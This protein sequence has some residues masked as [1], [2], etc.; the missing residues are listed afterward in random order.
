MA[1]TTLINSINFDKLLHSSGH[2][3]KLQDDF[4]NY[5]SEPEVLSSSHTQNELLS[6]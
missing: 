6:L 1:S 2:L 5:C 4:K 3:L